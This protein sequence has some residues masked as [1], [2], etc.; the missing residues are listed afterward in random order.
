VVDYRQLFLWPVVLAVGA[1][2]LL[3]FFFR[4]PTVRPT[5]PAKPVNV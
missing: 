1:T 2:L 4:P 3:A 5:D